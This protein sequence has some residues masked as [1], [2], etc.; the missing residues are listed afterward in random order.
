MALKK[1]TGL[2]LSS[3]TIWFVISGHCRSFT[4]LVSMISIW[5]VWGLYNWRLIATITRWKQG[6]VRKKSLFTMLKLYFL[7]KGYKIMEFMFKEESKEQIC[8]SIKNVAKRIFIPFLMNQWM[9]SSIVKIQ[10]ISCWE[11]GRSSMLHF[12]VFQ[13]NIASH[14]IF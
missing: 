10:N 2:G 3:D 14:L 9:F 7:V 12:D 1:P 6:K 4:M 13:W 5:I 11:C 8:V